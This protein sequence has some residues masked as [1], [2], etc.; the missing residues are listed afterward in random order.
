MAV[1]RLAVGGGKLK[2]EDAER[3]VKS[4]SRAARPHG[5]ASKPNPGA[6][7]ASGFAVRRVKV[8]PKK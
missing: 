5:G 8:P 4:W 2:S 3:L 7:M 6:L 1:N